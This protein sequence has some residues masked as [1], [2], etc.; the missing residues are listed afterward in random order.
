M[1]PSGSVSA[2]VKVEVVPESLMSSGF[3]PGN[4]PSMAVI[5]CLM[6]ETSTAPVRLKDSPASASTIN[7][8]LLSA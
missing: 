7:A 5:C 3:T 4:C 1:T 6:A 2:A 8:D